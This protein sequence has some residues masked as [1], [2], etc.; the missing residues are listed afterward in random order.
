MTVEK[1]TEMVSVL[2]WDIDRSGLGKIESYGKSVTDINAQILA[3]ALDVDL[4]L[5]ISPLLVPTDQR[6]LLNRIKFRKPI[7]KRR[8][9]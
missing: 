5:L 1:L 2:G 3:A 7:R 6:R 4:R 8:Y 9:F